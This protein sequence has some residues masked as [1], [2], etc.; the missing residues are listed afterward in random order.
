[1]MFYLNSLQ[2]RVV[3]PPSVGHGNVL[4]IVIY[5]LHIFNYDGPEEFI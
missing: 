2:V 3:R 1:M 5:S 4:L